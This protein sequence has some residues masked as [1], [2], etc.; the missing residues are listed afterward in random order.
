MVIEYGCVLGSIKHQ[1]KTPTACS[2]PNTGGPQSAQN[3]AVDG[4]AIFILLKYLEY[5]YIYNY[6]QL[7]AYIIMYV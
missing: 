3:G 1:E 6:I 5:I 4:D 7:Y 2:V